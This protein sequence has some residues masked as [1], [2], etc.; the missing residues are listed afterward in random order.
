MRLALPLVLAAL[1]APTAAAATWYVDVGPNGFFPGSITI[2][3]GDSVVWNNTDSVTHQAASTSGPASFDTGGIPIR[4]S[5]SP[6]TLTA[7]GTYAYADPKFQFTGT[8]VVQPPPNQPPA[9]SFSW[10]ATYLEVAFDGSP[11]T[12]ADGKVASWAW[13]FGDGAR[14]SGARVNHT[15]ASA[16]TYTVALTVTDDRGA[17]GSTRQSVAVGAPPPSPDI[18]PP[19]VAAFTVSVNDLRVDV[20]GSGSSDPNG[21]V[22]AWAWDFGDG[23][24]ASGPTANH[25][26]AQGG[27]FLVGLTVTDD[28]GASTLVRK[29][30]TV[31]EP[32]P[33]PDPRNNQPPVA[34]FTAR[35]SGLVLTV[36]PK[37]S[38]D[39]EGRAGLFQWRWGDGS[40]GYG[41]GV[42]THKYDAPNA[43]TVELVV[44]DE[45]GL[46]D[47]ARQTVRVGL[48]PPPPVAR[49]DASA[50]GLDARADAS[51]STSPEGRNLTFDWDFGDGVILQ[52]ASAV[53]THR[54]HR[55]GEFVVRVTA[56]DDAG[57]AGTAEAVVLAVADAT[58]EARADGLVVTLD[59]SDVPAYG[60][61]EY[62]WLVDGAR[63][64]LGPAVVT[65]QLSPG[66][67]EVTLVVR[68]DAGALT[69]TRGVLVANATDEGPFPEVRVG[70]FQQP[71]IPAPGLGLVLLVVLVAA[72]AR[73]R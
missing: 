21:K 50:N 58:F 41:N 30:V 49:L 29:T 9:A 8:I 55:P 36:D 18:N 56:R 16:G 53:A 65:E 25:T 37:G 44:T 60:D 6:I 39:P 7:A 70:E 34:T 2:A 22:V 26:Y 72:L 71:R 23:A 43:Y 42:T 73:R 31:S 51:A 64:A 19:P 59:A 52:N 17:T 54:Y 35:A 69:L 28:S 33:G 45:V 13:V 14:G 15:Y 10:G 11:S 40:V 32:P 3:S 57:G 62:E 27:D 48:P 63:V 66:A 24:T 67:H 68:D 46:S 4:S 5:S 20:D 47:V 12:D 38:G 61:A 1:L